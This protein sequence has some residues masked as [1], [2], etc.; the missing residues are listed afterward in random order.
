[1]IAGTILIWLWTSLKT[2]ASSFALSTHE[3][4]LPPATPDQQVYP[5]AND[6]DG[7]TARLSEGDTTIQSFLDTYRERLAHE[8]HP[9]QATSTAQP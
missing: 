7:S 3:R 1:M 4:S 8:L 5:R 6:G 9:I 2:S